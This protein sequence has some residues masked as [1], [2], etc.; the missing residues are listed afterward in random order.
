MQALSA[1]DGFPLWV[2]DVKP[3]SVHDLTAAREHVLGGPVLG[4]L[5]PRP[6]QPGRRRLRRRGH[7]RAHPGQTTR[8]R[9]GPRC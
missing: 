8:R 1:P 9:P 5:T 4:R 3:G 6:A 7:R 2:C